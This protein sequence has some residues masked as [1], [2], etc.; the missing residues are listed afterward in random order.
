MTIDPVALAKALGGHG[1]AAAVPILAGI[2]LFTP[3]EDFNRH[4]AESRTG[5]ILDLVD[6]AQRADGDFRAVLCRTLR[7]EL[8]QVCQDAPESAVCEDRLMYL[9]QAGCA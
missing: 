6:R 3:Q 1:S 2:L 8:A 5:T 7:Q 4:V 9:E